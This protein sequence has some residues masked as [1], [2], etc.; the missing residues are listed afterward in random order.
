MASTAGRQC[1]SRSI[2]AMAFAAKLGLDPEK[3]LNVVNSGSGRNSATADKWPRFLLPRD[4]TGGFST[5]LMHKDL[6]M[7]SDLAREMGS[8]MFILNQVRQIYGL[9]EAFDGAPVGAVVPV[10]SRT[11]AAVVAVGAGE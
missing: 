4:F 6:T 1:D 9:G 10:G 7:A 5:G 2:G 11:L 8:T 3:V